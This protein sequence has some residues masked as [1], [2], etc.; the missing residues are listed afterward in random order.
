MSASANVA[1]ASSERGEVDLDPAKFGAHIERMR[2]AC[3]LSRPALAEAS[4]IPED[5]I[6]GIEAATLEPNLTALVKL[7]HGL[8]LT[9]A[10]LWDGY[11]HSRP[12][13][14]RP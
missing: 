1:P 8:G 5:T 13:S 2:R 12:N 7:A 3:R 4:G 14:E 6:R 11:E 9:L 10:E